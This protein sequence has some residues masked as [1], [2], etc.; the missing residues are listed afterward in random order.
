MKTTKHSL[1]TKEMELVKQ[2]IAN[3]ENTGDVQAMLKRLFAGIIEQMLEAEMEE[4][5]DYEKNSAAGNNSCGMLGDA[6][7]NRHWQEKKAIYEKH[8]IIEGKNLIVSK[9]SISGGIDSATIKEQI[10]SFLS[11]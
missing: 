2:L 3:C 8:G 4:H 7:Y 11:R 6:G 1:N 10:D 5:L 9:D